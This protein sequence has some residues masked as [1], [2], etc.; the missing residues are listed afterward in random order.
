MG[1]LSCFFRY[2]REWDNFLGWACVSKWMYLYRKRLFKTLFFFSSTADELFALRR[3]TLLH[4]NAGV[5][6]W[7]NLNTEKS[8][9]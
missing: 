2:T 5:T 4:S 8:W 1:M 9:P 3:I 6:R 7:K